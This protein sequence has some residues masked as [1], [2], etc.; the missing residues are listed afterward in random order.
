MK[1]FLSNP[2]N[3]EIAVNDVLAYYDKRTDE[4]NLKSITAKIAKIR[5][6]VSEL[7]DAFVKAKSVL[8]QNSIETKMAE[9]EVLL[10]DLEMQKAQLELERGYKLT[11]KD[12]LV[13]IEE[14][15][16]GDVN[17][18]DYQ[19]QIIDYLVSQVFISDD[20]TVVYFNIR[21]GKDIEKLTIDD[22]KEVVEKVQ[23]QSPLARQNPK[24]LHFMRDFLCFDGENRDKGVPCGLRA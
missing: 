5:Q 15:L 4:Q 22:T 17:D 6:E 10:N 8:L 1:E 7:T 3:A 9:Y 11:K 23:T 20:N 13:F 12:L 19:K 21:G 16:K 18:K 24:I 14:L 2:E